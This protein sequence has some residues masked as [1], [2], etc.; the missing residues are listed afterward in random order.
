MINGTIILPFM[1]KMKFVFFSFLL[2][3]SA[4]VGSSQAAWYDNCELKSFKATAYY[5]PIEWQKFYVKWSLEEDRILNGNGTNGASWKKVFNGMIAAPKSYAFWTRIYIP[6]WGVGQVEDR[7]WAIVQ[8]W[9]RNEPFDRLDFWAWKWDAWLQAALRFWVRYFDAYVCPSWV[10]WNELWFSFTEVPLK[11]KVA[12]TLREVE[13]SPWST[14]QWTPVLQKYLKILWYLQ[15]VTESN[16]YWNQTKEAVCLY[17]Q[18]YMWMKKTSEW[19]GRFWKLTRTS[20]EKTLKSYTTDEQTTQQ[21]P[22][23]LTTQ[24]QQKQNNDFWLMKP[25]DEW[26]SVKQLQ[27]TLQWLWYYPFDNNITGIYDTLTVRA[28]YLFQREH[29][30]LAAESSSSLYGRIWPKTRDKLNS[31]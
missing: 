20:L 11:R 21:L 12:L 8:A 19:C 14:S 18:H 6:N 4:L 17:Q 13:L 1:F 30:L 29:D 26:E 2:L 23:K 15:W 16:Y 3:I 9:E 31:L 25:W 22:K 7:W 10:G 28:V 5:S 27:R 24:S